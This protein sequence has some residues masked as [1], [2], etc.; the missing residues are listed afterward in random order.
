MREE[1]LSKE[2][3]AQKGFDVH[4]SQVKI[5]HGN[6]HVDAILILGRQEQE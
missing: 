5:S 1:G 6:N 4:A 3:A 2:G